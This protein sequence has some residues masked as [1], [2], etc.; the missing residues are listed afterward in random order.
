MERAVER[1]GGKMGI[2]IPSLTRG[3]MRI[4]AEVGIGTPEA[5]FDPVGRQVQLP[6]HEGPPVPA[7]RS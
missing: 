1:P 6:Q 5:R 3:E 2:G 7:D 4:D